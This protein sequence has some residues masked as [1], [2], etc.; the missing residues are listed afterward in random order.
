[1]T[2]LT[3]SR[4]PGLSVHILRPPEPGFWW[5]DGACRQ[6]ATRLVPQVIQVPADATD[7]SALK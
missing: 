7:F 6:A 1:M 2:V 4:V 5:L 3:A